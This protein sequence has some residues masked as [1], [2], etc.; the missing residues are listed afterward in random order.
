MGKSFRPKF[1]IFFDFSTFTKKIE[2]FFFRKILHQFVS[3]N[4]I[5]LRKFE[6]FSQKLSLETFILSNPL[7]LKSGISVFKTW[8]DK[9]FFF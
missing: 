4:K 3:Q 9:G 8:S 1:R 2:I 5:Y 7:F 6:F